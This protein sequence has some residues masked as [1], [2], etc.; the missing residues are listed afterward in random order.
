MGA[1]QAASE[2]T[3]GRIVAAARE[4]LS[5]AGGIDAFTIDAVAAQAGVARMTVYYQ[6][7]SKTGLIE[8]VFDSLEIVR[9]GVPRL[10]A[11]LG[12]D[13]AAAALAE[14]VSVVAEAWQADRLV[15]RRL[16]GLAALD[17]AFA[18]VWHA[19]EG[20]RREGLRQIASRVAASRPDASLDVDAATAALFAIV[21]PEGFEAMA[22]G[23]RSF[24]AVAPVAHQLAGKALGL[25]GGEPVRFRRAARARRPRAR[26]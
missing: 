20:R 4:I 8:A 18:S 14:F 12:L 15:I 22:G 23:E 19:R 5:A 1:R 21:S 10:A 26:P 9:T 11:A 3:R 13:D 17:P 25:D 6:F 16:Q 7:G 24:D 2:E